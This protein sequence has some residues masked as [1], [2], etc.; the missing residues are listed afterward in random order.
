MTEE[1]VGDAFVGMQVMV[2]PRASLSPLSERL[3]IDPLF[4]AIHGVQRM[5]GL[6]LSRPLL[7]T[8]WIFC[9]DG[10]SVD[11]EGATSLLEIED[12][13]WSETL[14]GSFEI[15]AQW[16]F[17]VVQPQPPA[18]ADAES[19]LHVLAF[20]HNEYTHLLVDLLLLDQTVRV[21]VQTAFDSTVLDVY[22]VIAHGRIRLWALLS[23]SFVM[24]WHAPEGTMS[25]KAYEVPSVPSGSYVTMRVL[26]TMCIDDWSAATGNEHSRHATIHSTR[27]APGDGGNTATPLGQANEYFEDSDGSSLL[28]RNVMRRCRRWTLPGSVAVGEQAGSVDFHF[29]IFTRLAP[30]G[31]PIWWLNVDQEKMDD[32]FRVGSNEIVLDYQNRTRSLSLFDHLP[33]PASRQAISL[34]GALDRDKHEEMTISLP[35]FHPLLDALF[36]K[37]PASNLPMPEI[38]PLLPDDLVQG[39]QELR[40]I[41]PSNSDTLEIYTDGS[42]MPERSEEASWS[43]VVLCRHEGHYGFVHYEHG[44]V[45]TDPMMA[46]WC[47]NT[48]ANARAGEI[49]ALIRAIEWAMAAS[50]DLRQDFC[51]DAQ[52]VGYGAAG[53][54]G[55]SEGNVPMRILRSMSIALEVYL[56]G[57]IHWSHVKAHQGDLGNELAD[58]LAK[59]VLLSGRQSPP[60]VRPEYAAYS[61]GKRAPIENFWWV[62][63]ELDEPSDLPR[64]HAGSLTTGCLDPPPGTHQRLPQKLLDE[65]GAVKFV[66]KY[67]KISILTF[68]VTSLHPGRGMQH[69]VYLREQ[70]AAC[71]HHI[72]C[73]QETRARSSQLVVSQTHFRITSAA[74]GGKG[75]V[76]IWLMRAAKSGVQFVAKDSIR[77]LYA[78]RG[79][80]ILKATYQKFDLLIF[81]AHSPH[82]GSA[83]DELQTFW[84]ELTS[85]LERW[86]AEVPLFIGGIDGNAHVDV[87][88]LPH[89]GEFGLEAKPNAAGEYLKRLVQKLQAFSP[90][91][92][93]QFHS[94]HTHTWVSPANGQPARCDYIILPGE[95]SRGRIES[96]PQ[97][98]VDSGNAG[99]DHIPLVAD[100]QVLLSRRS[101]AGGWPRC[102]RQAL[103]Q[104]PTEQLQKMFALAPQISW[105]ADV[106]SHATQLSEWVSATL[107]KNFPLQG[108][109]PRKG[110]IQDDT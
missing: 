10:P 87:A 17:L 13:D 35:D 4:R 92:F 74:E 26:D 102:D 23:T 1:A 84:A 3:V 98:Y 99:H 97:P 56:P 5:L 41:V 88:C 11:A 20:V 28:Q 19:D 43:F 78:T 31:N 59:M 51:F 52:S 104:C 96:Y 66:D 85:E 69:V 81:S 9:T 110:Y 38:G 14:V 72:V 33:I 37:I 79:I 12:W 95:W 40:T 55:Y 60:R 29:S 42:F 27:N 36:C 63:T 77:V 86:T 16:A 109:R 91:T 76:E 57:F 21:A 47:G 67:L 30:P 44:L 24:L 89:L 18:K 6:D 2:R 15:S 94:G 45:E 49:I 71:G 83:S 100:V 8:S 108:N 70:L 50:H 101:Q 65:E 82:S 103:L 53:W 105:R 73:L 106:D 46:G 64:M 93:E 107:I 25:F 34:A 75:G 90:S 7:L 61:F 39:M 58:A 22:R 54:N 80:L 48:I 68:N 32:Y 62:F